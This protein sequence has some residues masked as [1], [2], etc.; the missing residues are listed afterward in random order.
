M[1]V[2]SDCYNTAKHDE[3]SYI[4]QGTKFNNTENTFKWENVTYKI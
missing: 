1:A 2:N 3:R 4:L